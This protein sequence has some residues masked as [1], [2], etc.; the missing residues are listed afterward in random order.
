MSGAAQTC[1]VL[2]V[3]GGP[4]A[5]LTAILLAQHG[6]NVITCEASHEIY[7]L[8]R[9][10]HLDHEVMRILQAAGVADVVAPQTRPVLLYDFITASGDVLLRFEVPPG[11]APGGWPASN[12]FHQPT[13]EH[14]LRARLAE[15]PNAALHTGWRC[16]ALDEDPGGIDA[17]FVTDDGTATVRARYVIGCDGAASF[18][19]KASGIG[20]EDL[21]F[22]EPWLVIDALVSDASRLPDRNLQ[23]CDPVRPTTSILLPTGRHRWEFMLKPDETAEAALEDAFIHAL[24]APWNVGGAITIERKAVYRFHALI[25]HQWRKGRV[26]LAGDSAHQM[27]PFAGQGLCSGL[28]DGANIAWKLAAVLRG[29]ASE[30]I[31]DTYQT[32]REPHVRAL[33]DSALLMGR[34]VCVLDPQI[35][36]ARDAVMLSARER[37]EAPPPPGA[38]KPFMAGFLASD[39]P[40]A[41]SLFPQLLGADGERLD[42]V[43]APNAWLITSATS[44]VIKS[45]SLRGH[46]L[47][48]S[49]LAPFRDPL[50]AWLQRNAAEAVLVRPDHY[51][52][53]T[54]KTSAL[55]DAYQHALTV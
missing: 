40:A 54:G 9:A 5:A 55:I 4:V 51:V 18:V 14:A 52:F 45:A 37:G 17:R 53:G 6:P 21:G 12:M 16:D 29:A 10:V 3:G 15:L 25:A 24:L 38:P 44:H 42:D 7:P 28:R 35:A 8:P 36:A 13:L 33:I 27:P 19:R 47:S 11:P 1:D 34:T 2:I 23:I 26:L 31:L 48:D 32:E 30:K 43:L 20:L 41:G 50:K 22:D 46:T 49:V 39:T